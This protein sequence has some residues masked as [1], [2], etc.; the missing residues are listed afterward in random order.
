MVRNG[1]IGRKWSETVEDGRNFEHYHKTFL[2][3]FLLKLF[4]I[5]VYGNKVLLHDLLNL[6]SYSNYLDDAFSDLPSHL[7]GPPL[8]PDVLKNHKLS[9]LVLRVLRLL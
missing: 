5:R 9:P 8:T 7:K 2:K 6:N 4:L 3:M 1:R